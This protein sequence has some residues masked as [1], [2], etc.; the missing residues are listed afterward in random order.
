MR[1]LARRYGAS[2]VHLLVHLA[3]IALALWAILHVLD[4]RN[5]R[6]VVVWFAAAL[7]A[8]DLILIPAYSALDRL[9]QR[10]RVAGLPAV[11]HIRVPAV[12]SGLLL[13]VYFPLI[14]GRADGNLRFVSGIEPSGYLERWLAIVAAVWLASAVVLGLRLLLR[15]QL[16]DPVVAPGDGDGA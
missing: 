7:I 11:N 12:V 8:Q 15:Q 5:A 4:L 6:N 14:S 16:R 10:V 9:A 13:L 3:A 1:A 2:P